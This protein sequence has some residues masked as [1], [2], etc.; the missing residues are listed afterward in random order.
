MMIMMMMTVAPKSF[1]LMII[2]MKCCKN[3]FEFCWKRAIS[4][5]HGNRGSCQ[6]TTSVSV[7]VCVWKKPHNICII[8]LFLLHYILTSLFSCQGEDGFPGFK[9]DMGIKGDRV[10]LLC[11]YCVNQISR[12]GSIIQMSCKSLTTVISVSKHVF[13]AKFCGG[14][15]LH[16]W[17]NPLWLLKNCG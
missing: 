16:T 6:D 12:A 13:G 8:Q 15:P 14:W 5:F 10:R 17:S 2:T 4:G 7:C 1:I 3:P 11:L 9:G